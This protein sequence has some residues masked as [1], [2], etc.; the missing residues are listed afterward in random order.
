AENGRIIDFNKRLAEMYGYDLEEIPGMLVFD[1]VT[2]QYREII[3]KHVSE[4]YDKPYELECLKKDGTLINVE[5]C[6]RSLEHEGRKIR[7]AA[8]RDI[9]QRKKMEKELKTLNEHLM[10]QVV[11][12]IEKIRTHEQ[13]LIQQSKMASM[14]EMIGL[15]AHQWRQPLNA[16]GLIVQELKDA[17]VYGEVDDTYLDNIVV[18]T[19]NQINF[20]SKTIE[21]FRNFFMPSK[22]KVTFDVKTIIEELLLMFID[23]FSKSNIDISIKAEQQPMLSVEGYPNEFKQ[24]VLNILNNSRDAIVSREKT[25]HE[26]H[27][28]IEINIY[29]NEDK[30]RVIVSIRDNGGGILDDVIEKIFE[31]YFTTKETDGTGI[32]LYMSKTIIETNM[33]G[34]LTVRN[35]DGGAEFLI[36]LKIISNTDGTTL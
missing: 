8:I 29:N 15:I 33:G 32:G 36:S 20:M 18:S 6:G 19:M 16:V 13:M 1:T 27:G 31:P 4:G 9:T 3:M 28:I 21:D 2:P 10:T 17:Y 34:N 25:S 26:T 7:M 30:S 12:G 5:V 11:A 23:I 35:I 24:V 22:N 14:G